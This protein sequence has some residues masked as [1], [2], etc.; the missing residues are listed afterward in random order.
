MKHWLGCILFLIW[1]MASTGCH[2]PSKDWHSLIPGI[3]TSSSPVLSDL[4]GDGVL[5]VII[6]A[7]GN[8]WEETDFGV[9]AL[10]GKTGQILWRHGARNQMVGTAMLSDLNEDGIDDVVIGG[11]S[12]ELQAL[13]GQTGNLLWQFFSP[14]GKMSV[15]DAGW[16][17]FYNGQWVS[18]Q[19]ADGVR[20]LII[21]NGGDALLPAEAKIRPAGKL[22][23]LSG[24]TGQILHEIQMPDGKET[25]FTPVCIDCGGINPRVIVG[26]GGETIS[27]H[28]YLT[29]LDALKL[30]EYDRFTVI[31]SSFAKGYIAPPVI[32]DMDYVGG[33]DLIYNDSEARISRYSL[34]EN[35][36]VWST[37]TDS[38][39]VYTRPATGNFYKKDSIPD[40]FAVSAKGVYPFYTQFSFRLLDGRDGKEVWN[41]SPGKF[42]YASPLI[43]DVNG[44]GF[45][46]AIV[47]VMKD[48]LLSGQKRPSPF[49]SVEVID[50]QTGEISRLSESFPGSCFA[51]TPTLVDMDGDGLAELIWVT[52]PAIISDFPGYTTFQKP[53]L[54]MT[55]HKTSTNIKVSEIRRGSYLGLEGRCVE[56]LDPKDYDSSFTV[57]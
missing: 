4:N 10:D 46:E 36:I 47:V 7:G 39:E 30:G 12:A 56:G 15:R 13:D 57:R 21:C 41:A 25:Y 8:E 17:N 49:V 18:D 24:K 45:D 33:F 20:D 1:G 3:S 31:D 6:G 11:R 53:A 14:D 38:S 54:E 37:S 35:K 9:L 32:T 50:F 52:S 28:L 19:N 26:S 34:R 40:V 29:D 22:L 51:S 5:D 2:S 23:L 44:D 43:A 27:G 55:I 16:F 42:T 48:S